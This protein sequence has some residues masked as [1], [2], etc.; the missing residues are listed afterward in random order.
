MIVNIKTMPKFFLFHLIVLIIAFGCSKRDAPLPSTIA[1]VQNEY[2]NAYP[3]APGNYWIYRTHNFTP[4]G[5]QKFE[6]TDSVWIEKDTIINKKRYFIERSTAYWPLKRLLHDSAGS[7]ISELAGIK[8]V[9]FSS[10]LKDTLLKQTPYYRLN[11][12]KGKEIQVLAGRFPT[13][14]CILL[15]KLDKATGITHDHPLYNADFM[16]IE[17]LLYANNVGLVKDVS[18]YVGNT[19]EKRLERYSVKK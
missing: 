18:Y 8:E 7:V 15:Y 11:V 6:N 4:E 12:D 2:S 13:I 17:Q 10:N 3:L 9:I 14:N 19:I 5:E 1:P 16:I